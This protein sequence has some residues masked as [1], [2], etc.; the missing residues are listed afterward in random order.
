MI[1]AVIR[2][3]LILALDV[4]DA[5]KAL[6]WVEKTREWVGMFKVGSQ[7]FTQVGPSLVQ[8]IQDKGGKVFLDLKFHDIPNTVAACAEAAVDMGVALFNVHASG[9][10][11]MMSA[12]MQAVKERAKAKGTACPKVL[13]V[14]VLT[15]MDDAILRTELG[16]NRSTPEQVVHLAKLAKQA[17]MDGVVASPKEITQIRKSCSAPFLILT[18]GIRSSEDPPDDQK[19]SLTAA[20]AMECGADYLVL[21]RTVTSSHYDPIARLR[22]IHADLARVS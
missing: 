11:S 13:A 15:S 7:L 21:G 4:H 12:C 6:E 1:D 5:W 19:R 18:P 8:N 10:L 2:D 14:T 16:V 17:G 20:E 9:G 3:K 22:G